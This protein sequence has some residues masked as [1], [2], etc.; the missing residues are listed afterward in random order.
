MHP[1][2]HV[3]LLTALLLVLAAC[4]AAATTTPSRSEPATAPASAAASEAPTATPEPT[5]TPEPTPGVGVQVLVGDQQYVTVTL[6]E[7]WAGTDQLKPAAGNVYITVNIRI[8]AI[9][10]TSFA[11]EDFSLKD[12]D[13]NVYDQI[14]GRSPRLSF[15]DG[16]EPNHNY[17][18]FVTF[19]IPADMNADLTLVYA[20][21]FLTTTYEIPLS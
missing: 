21:S 13:G 5:N 9:T 7:Q 11:S 10:T 8:D 1:I 19:E 12:G 17:A 2:R 14:L 4:N 3:L 15:L 20:P 18:G 16:L 6:A